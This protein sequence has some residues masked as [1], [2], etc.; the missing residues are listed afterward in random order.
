MKKKLI[1]MIMAMIL[2]VLS[3]G[4]TKQQVSSQIERTEVIMGTV[5]KIT[6]YEGGSKEI[7]DKAFER[8]AE[9]ESLVSINKEGTE[10]E[11]LNKNAGINGVKVSDTSYDIIEKA[12][13]YSE[14]SNGGY[15]LTIGPLVKLWGIGMP[16]AKVPTQV[17]IDETIK[18]I[19]YSK[20]KINPNT[21]EVF[22]SEEGLMIDLGS[23]AKG[24]TADEVVKLLREEGVEQA[25]VDLG[26]NI[27]AMGLKDGDTN[28]KIG[29]QSPFNDRGNTV[30][31][32]EVSDK[33]VVTSGV[34][35]RFVEKD[36]VKYHHILNPDTGYPY[37]TEIAGVSIIADKSIDADAL[38]TLI[39][40]KGLDEGLDMVEK[41]DKIDAVFITNKKEVYITEG[42]R[43]NFEITNKEFKLSN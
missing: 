33:T 21:K 7:L 15:D 26:G 12:L 43:G 4:C 41:L 14:M 37:E 22:L 11:E 35:E 3:I 27:Y 28:W 29:I 36:G 30:G 13:Y 1:I 16:N 32:V 39:F 8:I 17:E 18:K 19:D 40:T 2:S 42:L 25:I 6:L 24:Y 31:S 10:I 34:Y 5:V 9:I 23:I 20:V 38:S